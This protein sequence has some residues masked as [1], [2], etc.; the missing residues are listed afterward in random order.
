[1]TSALARKLLIKPGNRVLILNAPVR[2]DELLAP[3]PENATLH[4]EPKGIYDVVHLFAA[5]RDQLEQHAADAL[6]SL[7]PNGILWIS[8][9]KASSGLQTDL[10][11]DHGWDVIWDAGRENVAQVSVDATWSAGRF[12]RSETVRRSAKA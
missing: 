9:P 7:E 3:L 1:M 4:S 6:T 12:K 11:R 8:Y 10:T 5:D 2:F